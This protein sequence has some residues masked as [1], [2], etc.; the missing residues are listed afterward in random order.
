MIFKDILPI[1]ID[2]FQDM[3][4]KEIFSRDRLITL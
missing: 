4:E 1:L 3:P 2:R